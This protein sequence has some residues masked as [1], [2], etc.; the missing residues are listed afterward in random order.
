MKDDRSKEHELQDFFDDVQ[1]I[2]RL[3]FFLSLSLLVLP[4]SLSS[5][6]PSKI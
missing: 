3:Y 6:C 5:V 4:P 1:R 2:T